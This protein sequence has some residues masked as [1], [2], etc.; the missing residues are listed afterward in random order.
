MCAISSLF[1]ILNWS[2][3]KPL[4]NP[5]YDEKGISLHH[6]LQILTK[7]YSMFDRFS[8]I[9]PEKSTYKYKLVIYAFLRGNQAIGIYI[10]HFLLFLLNHVS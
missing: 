8:W 2:Q 10:L 3:N 1:W 5:K 6:K 7:K 4:T 9:L